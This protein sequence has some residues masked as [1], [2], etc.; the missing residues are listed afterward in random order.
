[1]CI[2]DGHGWIS[3]DSMSC[4]SIAFGVTLLLCDTLSV[5]VEGIGVITNIS[6]GVATSEKITT[7]EMISSVTTDQRTATS[8]EPDG[9]VSSAPAITAMLVVV[10]LLLIG[11]QTFLSRNK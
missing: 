3:A 4:T 10:N 2:D 9:G 1:M 5:Q 11:N 8:T 7:H 6:S